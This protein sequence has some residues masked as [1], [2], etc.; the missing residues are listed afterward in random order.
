MLQCVDV[1]LESISTATRNA[2]IKVS[3]SSTCLAIFTASVV[4]EAHGCSCDSSISPVSSQSESSITATVNSHC[5]ACRLYGLYEQVAQLSQRD[6]AAGWVSYGK[7]WKTGTGR[8]YFMDIIGLSSTTVIGQ[9]SN[10]IRWKNAK[11]RLLCRSRSFKVIEV[12]INR[13]PICDFLLVINSNWHPISYRFRVIATYCSN[14]GHCV[15]QSPLGGGLWNNVRCSSWA[16]WKACSGLPINVNWT[17]LL[18]LTA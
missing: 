16:H 10:Q 12:G 2:S 7:K 13:K 18:G 9:H 14:S 5:N 15:F 8:Q 11:Y 3:V 17:F 6:C 1:E 4:L